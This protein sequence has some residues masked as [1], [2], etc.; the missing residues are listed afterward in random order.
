MALAYVDGPVSGRRARCRPYDTAAL[1]AELGQ[2]TWTGGGTG[3]SDAAPAAVSVGAPVLV[4]D[5]AAGRGYEIT[6]NGVAGSKSASVY[7]VA[8]PAGGW[9][10]RSVALS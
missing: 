3:S 6:V 5:T 4:D 10:A 8:T 9:L 7:V 2:P 1:D